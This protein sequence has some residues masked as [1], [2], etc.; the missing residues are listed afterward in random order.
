[1]PCRNVPCDVDEDELREVFLQF[2]PVR[3]CRAVLDPVSGSCRGSMYV[4]HLLAAIAVIA[5]H[6]NVSLGSAFVQFRNAFSVQPCLETSASDEVIK[7]KLKV[8]PLTRLLLSCFPLSS[9][10]SLS[11]LLSLF[12]SPPSSDSF[13][14]F[15]F[16][17]RACGLMA[18]GWM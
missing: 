16:P 12:L 1:M 9:S 7:Q 14:S 2:G 5:P 8:L 17:R 15:F 18:A 11:L 13:S 3:Y 10:L 6:G 4:V